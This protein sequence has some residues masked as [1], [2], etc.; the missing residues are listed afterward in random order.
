MIGPKKIWKMEQILETE[1][2]EARAYTW[3]QLEFEVGLEC[4]GRTAQRAM[5]TMDY[6]KCI[7]CTRGWVNEKTAR[8]RMNW[9]TVMPEKCPQPENWH[10]V[11]F[12]GEVHFG[13]GTQG[14]HRI[15]RKAG[16]R[17]GQDC[18]EQVH[19]L[20]GKDKKR[21][22]CCAA[23]GHSFRS[24]IHFCEV[25]GNTNGKMSQQVYINKILEPIVKPW[26]QAHQDFVSEED[27]SQTLCVHGRSKMTWNPLSTVIVLQIWPL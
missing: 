3:E 24:D 14:K 19:E 4:S 12:S 17:Y 2:I 16:M 20:T 18:I 11:R 27:G 13:Y 25:P 6:H 10:R 22:H 26:L 9:A 15:I 8:D 23:V 1:G 5:G 21:Y 7:A